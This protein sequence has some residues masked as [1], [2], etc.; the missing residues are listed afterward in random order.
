MAESPVMGPFTYQTV[1]CVSQ[2]IEH[3]GLQ[4]HHYGSRNAFTMKSV[5]DTIRNQRK[6]NVI[7]LICVK[8]NQS[9][10]KGHVQ[11]YNLCRCPSFLG[12]FI[13]N[14]QLFYPRKS[15]YVLNSG[16]LTQ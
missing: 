10:Y 14:I 1:S 15:C 6:S 9:S 7:L 13:N 11:E 12:R 3:R 8:V 2:D 5:G 16:L 4:L